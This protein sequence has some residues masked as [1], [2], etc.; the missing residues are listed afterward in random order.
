MNPM[1]PPPKRRADASGLTLDAFGV[2][3]TWE[4]AAACIQPDAPP[5]DAFFP[6]RQSG[7]ANHG[8]EAKAT[9]AGCPVVAECLVDSLDRHEKFG[10][11]GGAGE[12]TRRALIRRWQSRGHEVA[13]DPACGCVSCAAI[14]AHLDALVEGRRGAVLLAAGERAGP[15]ASSYNRGDRSDASSLARAL[16]DVGVRPLTPDGWWRSDGEAA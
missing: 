12:S 9:C 4:L 2:V 13:F 5:A 6:V 3:K 7:S 8:A 11:R 16:Y 1:T 15:S 10:I 14:T